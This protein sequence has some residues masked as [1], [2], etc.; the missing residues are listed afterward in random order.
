MDSAVGPS[1][2]CEAEC[3]CYAA[4]YT[5]LPVAAAFPGNDEDMENPTGIRFP[6]LQY[7]QRRRPARACVR[8]RTVDGIDSSQPAA[9]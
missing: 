5:V 4:G 3:R 7:V 2:V 9:G 6:V 8:H 1:L